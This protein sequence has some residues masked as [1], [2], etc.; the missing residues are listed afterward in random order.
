MLSRRVQAVFAV[1]LALF[2]IL[3]AGGFEWLR[4]RELTFDGLWNART[5]LWAGLLLFDNLVVVWWYANL[6]RQAVEAG[7]QQGQLTREVIDVSR[8]QAQASGDQFMLAREAD[9]RAQRPCVVIEWHRKAAPGPGFPEGHTYVA[10]N[11]GSGLALN[12]AHIENLDSRDLQLDH[13]GALGAGESVEL[14]NRLVE[15]LNCETPVDRRRHVLIAEPVGGHEWVIS[16]NL[17]ESTERISHRIRTRRLTEAELAR[18]H[19][20]TADE[21]IH[22][23]WLEIQAD[24]NR[25]LAALQE[26]A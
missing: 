20:Q 24:L 21:Y 18:I 23:H 12:V 26:R 14:P 3:V 15:M 10:R 25:L 13:I 22:E 2:N 16:E 7:R 11:I 6:T 4:P 1:V 19:R 5:A 9:K 8:Q 17:R